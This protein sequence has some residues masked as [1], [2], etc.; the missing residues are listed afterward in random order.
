[1]FYLINVHCT[2]YI[3][4]TKNLPVL[5]SNVLLYILFS[6][7]TISRVAVSPVGTVEVI[8]TGQSQPKG[9]AVDP[10]SR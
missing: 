6:G 4:Y 7:E 2:I 1:M 3:I 10:F 5:G 8:M 9:I